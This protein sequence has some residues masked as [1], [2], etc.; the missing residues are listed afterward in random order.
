MSIYVN[1]RVIDEVFDTIELQGKVLE[2][3]ELLHTIENTFAGRL[4][5][6]YERAAYELK[7]EGWTLAQIADELNVP[8]KA[9]P[10]LLRAY[11]NRTGK[12]NLL[13]VRSFTGNVVDIRSL[14]GKEAVSR[15]QSTETS[16]PTA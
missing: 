2:R 1:P 16:H 9:V 6:S 5:D 7:N 4:L 8:N 12:P 14:V 13:P 10:G 11:Q 15:R 3:I